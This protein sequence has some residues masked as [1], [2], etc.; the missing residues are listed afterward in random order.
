[1]GDEV[2]FRVEDKT[3]YITLNRPEQGNALNLAMRRL[4][5]DAWRRVNSDPAI[6]SVI[7]TGGD[8]VFSTG[9]DLKEL[10]EFR[11][12]EPIADL[13]M[14]TL[15]TYGINVKKP[16][17]AAIS[18]YCL[19]AGFLLA[20]VGADIRVASTTAKFGM[21]E[22]KVGVPPSLGI[23]PLIAMHFP[24]AVA[25]KLLLLGENLTVEEAY[26]IGFVNKV[27]EPSELI[28]AAQAYASKINALS[29]LIVKNIKTV[30]R[31][32]TAPDPKAIALSDA[33][34][35]LGRHSEDYIEGWKAFVQKRKPRWT[36]K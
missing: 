13:P 1:M 24:P 36:G 14:N 20:L 32:V 9:Q 29:P 35:L 6:C 3:A 15:D 18:G 10:A 25:M 23:P 12:T 33:V 4:L 34:C 8:S 30:Y 22:V 27:V 11:K 17:I 31:K 26:Q 7:I 16:V 21:P 5:C 19:G 28:R 2:I